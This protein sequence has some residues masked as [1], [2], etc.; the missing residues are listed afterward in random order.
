MATQPIGAES[1]PVT[2]PGTI[3]PAPAVMRILDQFSR[4]E[5]GHTIEVL[6]AL[7][8]IWDAPDNPDEPDFSPCS[9]GLPGDPRDE[10]LGGDKEAGSYVEWDQM[11]GSQKR[12]PNLVGAHEDDEDDDPDCG[13]DEAEPNFVSVECWEGGAGCPIADP[14]ADEH[15]GRE[16]GEDEER[17]QMLHDVPSLEVWSLDHNPF[18]DRRV[19]LG[20]SNLQS[21]FV[22]TS[23]VLSADTGTIHKSFAPT[24]RSQPGV[25]V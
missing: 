7:L 13:L 20:Y 22:A 11:R 14:G 2:L 15:D 10:E 24:L 19:S 16:P 25:P 18:T 6:V 4:E 17:E 21:S 1:F 5:L 8:D 3:P 12:G 23:G 9:D